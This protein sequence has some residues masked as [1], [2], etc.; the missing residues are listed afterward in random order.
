MEVSFSGQRA[1]SMLWV[2]TVKPLALPGLQPRP[3]ARLCVRGN[4]ERDKALIVSFSPTVSR[5]TVRLLL[6]LLSPMGW[7][8]R[9]VDV[10]TA[11]LQGMP[12]HRPAPVYVRPPVEAGVSPGFLWLFAKCAYGLVDAPRMWYERVFALM[13]QLGTVRS[14]AD[15]CLF[16][17]VQSGAVILVVALHVDDFLFGGTVAGVALF[18]QE[19][20]AAFSVGPV[21]VG[22]F[23]FTGLAVAFWAASGGQPARIRVDQQMYVGSLDDILI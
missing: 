3:K 2:L 22:S 5:S 9:T 6:I 12:I 19:L 8:P 17:L 11:F 7:E 10:S 18:E 15:P 16:V 1:L 21:A 20:R 23:V 13:R 4:E 14:P